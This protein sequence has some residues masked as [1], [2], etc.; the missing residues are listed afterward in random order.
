MGKNVI[1]SGYDNAFD[2]MEKC[3]VAGCDRS[4]L[5]DKIKKDWSPE[6]VDA[7]NIVFKDLIFVLPVYFALCGDSSQRI[8]RT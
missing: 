6:E 3:V 1:I 8:S 2:L 7:S 4:K 5:S